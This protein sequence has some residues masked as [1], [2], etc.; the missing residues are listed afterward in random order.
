[1]PVTTSPTSSVGFVVYQV[2]VNGKA[3]SDIPLD[4]RVEQTWGQHDLVSVRIEYNRM[5]PASSIYVP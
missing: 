5:R 3:L 1:M 4:V 2:Y